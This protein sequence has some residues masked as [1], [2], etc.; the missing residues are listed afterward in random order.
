MINHNIQIIGSII[1]IQNRFFF[2]AILHNTYISQIGIMD[3]RHFL[4]AFL[5]I[6]HRQIILNNRIIK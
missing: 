1:N 5:N 4:P 3:S 2:H 6:I